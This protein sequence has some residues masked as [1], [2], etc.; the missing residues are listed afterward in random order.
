M[1]ELEGQEVEQALQSE[2]LIE[3]S[4]FDRVPE[5]NRYSFVVRDQLEVTPIKQQG[6]DTTLLAYDSEGRYIDGSW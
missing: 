1:R 5:H 4:K 2:R 6:F 3:P